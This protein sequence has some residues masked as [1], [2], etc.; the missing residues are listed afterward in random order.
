ML[1]RIYAHRA[2]I[3]SVATTARTTTSILIKEHRPAPLGCQVL[4]HPGEHFGHPLKIRVH[5]RPAIGLGQ[6]D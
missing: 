5:H 1:I 4:S 2:E 3:E 6:P